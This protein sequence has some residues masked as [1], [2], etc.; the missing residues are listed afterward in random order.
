MFGRVVSILEGAR[1]NVVRSVNSEMVVAYWLI[2]REIV[3]E[4]QRGE[5]RAE[6]GLQ[7]LKTLSE[8]LNTH[9][10]KGFSVQNL[11]LFRRFY[12]AFQDRNLDG[13]GD[14][15]K[16]PTHC[17]G[18]SAGFV[19]SLGWS[20][21]RALMRVEHPAARA[22][23]EREAASNGWSVRQLERQIH[24]LFFERLLKSSEREKM[25]AQLAAEPSELK[26]ID[27]IKDPY[28]LEFLDLPEAHQ[29]TEDALENA[30]INGLQQF[31]LELGSGFSFVAR[32]MR[33]TL[34][35]DHFYPDLVFYHI[36]LKCHVVVDLKLEK[37]VHGDVGQMQLYV[38][39]FDREVRGADD[40]PT[41]GL[42]LCTEKNDSM[43]RY[44]LGEEN[45]QVFAS[46]YQLALPTKE[47]L[48]KELRKERLMIEEG[49]EQYGAR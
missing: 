37:L 31:L 24:T 5:G 41:V 26:P 13:C 39:Y 20:H 49:I 21:Y 28:V 19:P 30:L 14:A 44:I 47:E 42:L 8:K 32:Q 45:K 15:D 16:N 25:E 48:E 23:Y 29:L 34:E 11:E 46:K 18:Y 10:K 1:S 40:N 36:R 4:I 3:E 35:G 7:L 9:F 38:N 17:V 2:G 6:Y 33:I 12:L 43:V 22:Y 27:V